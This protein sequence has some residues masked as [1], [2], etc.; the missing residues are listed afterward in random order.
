MTLTVFSVQITHYYYS[1]HS[2]GILPVINKDVLS[3]KQTTTQNK[4]TTSMCCYASIALQ[5]CT[6]SMLLLYMMPTPN[7]RGEVQTLACNDHRDNHRGPLFTELLMG[8]F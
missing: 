6:A 4:N 1:H 5:R 7:H 3:P 8:L 2:V